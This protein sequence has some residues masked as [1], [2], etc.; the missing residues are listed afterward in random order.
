MYSK[1]DVTDLKLSFLKYVNNFNRWS[2][3]SITKSII[4]EKMQLNNSFTH[5]S[6]TRWWALISK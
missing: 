1:Q 2:V 6:L 4:P 3:L 5:S